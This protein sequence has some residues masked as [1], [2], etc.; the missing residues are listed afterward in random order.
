MNSFNHYA[1]GAVGEWMYRVMAGIDLD[2]AQ[3]S[4]RHIIIAPRPGGSFTSVA[5]SHESMY[6]R[7]A[8]SW[9]KEGAGMELAVEIPPNTRA[10]VR[11][12]AAQLAKVTEDG[13]PLAGRPGVTGVRQDGDSVV[14]ETGSGSYR[15][16][17]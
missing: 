14:V 4:Y 2:P 1:Y 5:A 6:G 16:R 8:S 15:F 11:L 17:W 13:G 9:K 12:P 7:V 10:T 3:P